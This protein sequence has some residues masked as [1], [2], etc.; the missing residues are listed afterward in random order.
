MEPRDAEGLAHCPTATAVFTSTDRFSPLHNSR[1]TSA[2]THQPLHISRYTS[3]KEILTDGFELEERDEVAA[4]AAG[5]G[6]YLAQNH[7]LV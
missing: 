3:A 7:D 5:L 2:V 6:P 1:Y 4:A